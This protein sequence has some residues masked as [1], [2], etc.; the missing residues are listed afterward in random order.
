[1]V[2]DGAGFIEID[3]VAAERRLQGNP[4]LEFLR[5]PSMS[6]GL[7]VLP[8]GGADAQLPHKQDE[9]YYVIR[10]KARM[11]A[12]PHDQAIGRGSLVFVAA[13]VE[14]RFHRI[15]EE[16]EILVFFAPAESE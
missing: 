5:V 13:N 3:D 7:Y 16:L 14:H 1:M 12:G 6:A 11:Q 9:L 4:Y 8:A 10:G 2:R 15:E